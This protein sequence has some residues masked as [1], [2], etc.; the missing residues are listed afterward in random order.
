M[1]GRSEK[2]DGE[3]EKK[4]K[5]GENKRRNKGKETKRKEK[6]FTYSLPNKNHFYRIFYT[7]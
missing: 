7:R 3:E 1:R 5:I 6:V 4:G 2:K